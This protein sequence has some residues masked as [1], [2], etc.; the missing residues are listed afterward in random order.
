MKKILIVEDDPF[1]VDIYTTKLKRVGYR[2]IVAF[3]GDEGLRKVQEEKPDLVLLD[4]VLP[5]VDGWEFLQ[6]A[7]EINQDLKVVI[8]SNLNKKG[9]IEK[10][11]KMGAT[12][13]L[14]KAN[15]TPSEVVEEIKELLE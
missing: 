11:L 1:M 8:L 7:K 15:Y 4:I 13:Y 14:I 2:V 5:I 9:E 6:R 10:G 3:D 12:K